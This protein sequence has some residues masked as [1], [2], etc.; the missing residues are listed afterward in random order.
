MNWGFNKSPA[1]R[2]LWDVGLE[3]ET[4]RNY[5]WGKMRPN[6]QPLYHCVA[7]QQL[8]LSLRFHHKLNCCSKYQK[9]E[10]EDA[11]TTGKDLSLNQIELRWLQVVQS[12][13]GPGCNA[14]QTG[15][16]P[17]WK[18]SKESCD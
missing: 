2:L 4:I 6:N 3:G 10:W 5:C 8:L 15:S 9:I 11:R 17:G 16:C 18:V 14:S 12:I 1:N 13:R 7:G